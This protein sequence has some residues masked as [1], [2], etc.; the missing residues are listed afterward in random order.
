MMAEKE[1][2]VI[3]ELKAVKDEIN[4]L[5]KSG[6]EFKQN[7]E[8]M[9]KKE[10]A[11]LGEINEQIER[12]ITVM[13][14]SAVKK[15]INRE[16][17]SLKV[18]RRRIRQQVR[19]QISKEISRVTEKLLPELR[20]MVKEEVKRTSLDI[21]NQLKRQT[22]RQLQ[23]EVK[24]Q[25]KESTSVLR[26]QAEE[27]EKKAITDGLTG[28]F[29]RRFFET[30]LEEELNLA[31]RFRNKLCLVMFDIDHFKEVNDTY[32]HQAG[33]VI[34]AEVAQVAGSMITSVDSLCR[35]GGEEFAVIMPETGVEKAVETAEKIRA[36][37]QD[38]AFY[39]GDRLINVTASFGAA[40]YP[41]HSLIKQALIEKADG[42]LYYA[43]HSGRNNV[44]AAIK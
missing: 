12:E 6:L 4:L 38:H 40:E 22:G 11:F 20:N 2:D 33:D 16:T 29:N 34:L 17:V 32:G 31:K 25:I 1:T 39:G 27:S 24:E 8:E 18:L 37:I 21:I 7:Y 15:S 41:T 19:R 10:E 13:V 5:K 26:E 30:K 3:K 14:L 35:Y 44:K 43:K 36:A 23:S 9:L 42:A 28:A